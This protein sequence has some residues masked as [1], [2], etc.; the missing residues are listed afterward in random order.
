MCSVRLAVAKFV[1]V[2]NVVVDERRLVERFDRDGRPA[3]R[4]GESPCDLVGAVGLV[5]WPPVRAS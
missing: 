3:D 4:V 5:Q 2:L 1:A